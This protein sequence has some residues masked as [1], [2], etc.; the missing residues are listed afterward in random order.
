MQPESQTPD[1]ST[2]PAVKPPAEPALPQQP[3]TQLQTK[4]TEPLVEPG[5]QLIAVA[6]RHPIGLVAIYLGAAVALAAIL[7]LSFFVIPDKAVN[8]MSN[9]ASNTIVAATLLAVILLAIILVAFV[10]VYKQSKLIIT[11]KSLVQVIQRSLFNRKISRLSMSNVEDVNAEKSGIIPTIFNY[12]TV[13]VETAG[14]EDN[15]IFPW[16]PDPDKY[17][18][19]ILK[20]RQ[21]YV[22]KYGELEHPKA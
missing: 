11:D 19:N 17:A 6:R 21:Q 20:A 15:F 3:A 1:S 16:C 18:D 10:R 4:T 9:S 8:N 22:Q 2:P 14:E 12:G 7:T 5:E 13:T